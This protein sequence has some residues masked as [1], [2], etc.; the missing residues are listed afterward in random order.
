MTPMQQMLHADPDEAAASF[1]RAMTCKPHLE[2]VTANLRQG[3]EA[4]DL[5]VLHEI[6]PQQLLSRGDYSIGAARQILFFHPRLMVRVLA[7]D[8][9]ALLEPPLK[10]A[11]LALPDGGVS[12]RW[13][14]PAAAFARYAH[15]ALLAWGGSFPAPARPS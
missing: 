10:F 1:Q 5:W 8:P 6:N 12:V 4:N 11:V 9:A 13:M 14:A 2:R 7:A 15:P 3:I